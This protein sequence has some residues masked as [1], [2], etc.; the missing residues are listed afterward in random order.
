MAQ[1]DQ[2]LQGEFRRL[3]DDRYRLSIPSSLADPL[4]AA[5]PECIAVKERP[6]AISLWSAGSWETR[7]DAGLQ[8]VREKIQAGRLEGK[9]DQVQQLGRL[10]STRQRSVQLAGRGRLLIPEGFREFLGVEPGGEVIVI[11]AAVCVE[12]WQPTSWLDCLQV[13]IPQFRELFDD[14]SG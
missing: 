9:I 11:G 5:G 1:S 8:V 3:M 13:Q 10:L 12:L 2:L 14:L 4:T 7:L 6:G